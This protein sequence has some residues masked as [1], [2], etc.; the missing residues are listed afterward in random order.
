[1][2]KRTVARVLIALMLLV[3][4]G[5]A[6]E[7][8]STAPT[9][10]PASEA[11]EQT[12][13]PT[14]NNAP[15]LIGFVIA[16]DGAIG[17]YMAMYGFLHTAEILGYP[18]KLYRASG[19]EAAK[20]AV[21]EAVA[22][23]CKGLLVLNPNGVNDEAV[24]LAAQSGIHV[25]VPYDACGVEGI[26]ANIVADTSEY[27]EEV[28]RGLSVRMTER[29][30]KSGRILVYGN[31]TSA[32]YASFVED[33]QAYYPQFGVTSFDRAAA[34]DEAAIDELARFLLYNR[35]IKGMYVAD[36]NLASIAVKARARAKSIF[37]SS[38][39]PSPTPSPSLDPNVTPSPTPNPALLKSITIT[40]FASGLS[41]ENYALFNGSDIYAL[42]IEPYYEAVA[43]STMTLDKLLHG[44]TVPAVSRVNRPIAYA[45]T[46]DKYLA[47]QQQVKDLFGLS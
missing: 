33:I 25:I 44:D 28:A 45:D 1:M 10:P 13:A 41:D 17:S 36:S 19:G 21:S 32:V 16:D 27:V 18:A 35:D 15:R 14:G 26:D 5:C 40:V 2:L 34:D 47:I 8:A 12:P 42:C 46:I 11:V 30:L 37:E 9:E 39:T 6:K 43:Q 22:D 24:R 31:D 38:G 4:A 20:N 7:P 23:G 29:G 3:S